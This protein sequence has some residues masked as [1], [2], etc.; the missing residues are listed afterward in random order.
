MNSMQQTAQWLTTFPVRISATL[1]AFRCRLFCLHLSHICCPFKHCVRYATENT[2]QPIRPKTMRHELSAA[3]LLRDGLNLQFSNVL[4]KII[5]CRRMIDAWRTVDSDKGVLCVHCIM[6]STVLL[7][8]PFA[9]RPVVRLGSF[10]VYIY[11]DINACS[12]KWELRSGNS[13]GGGDALFS[14]LRVVY[15]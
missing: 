5:A 13:W 3:L 9:R 4:A 14:G 11:S 15:I 6:A 7:T 1:S 10:S 2:I 12:A 8:Q